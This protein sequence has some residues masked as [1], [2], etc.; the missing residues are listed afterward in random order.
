MLLRFLVYLSNIYLFY[1]N[2][3]KSNTQKI[4]KVAKVSSHYSTPTLIAWNRIKKKRMQFTYM[5]Y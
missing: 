2:E 5:N 1:S 4:F 3:L